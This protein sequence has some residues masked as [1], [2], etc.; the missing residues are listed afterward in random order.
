[1]EQGT[2]L[3]RQYLCGDDTAAEADTDYF[4]MIFTLEEPNEGPLTMELRD[5]VLLRGE[6]E[7]WLKEEETWVFEKLEFAVAGEPVELL[8]APVTIKAENAIYEGNC[9]VQLDSVQLRTFALHIS[10]SHMNQAGGPEL[11]GLL[12]LKD[13]STYELRFS[14][15]GGSA[16]GTL[17]TVFGFPVLPEEVD[18]ILLEGI[19]LDIP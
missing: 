1:M 3:Y 6:T 9:T 11:E 7:D 14:C 19:R 13:G 15:S 17:E 16:G 5:M 10:Y 4:V 12:V 2:E 8:A 18:H